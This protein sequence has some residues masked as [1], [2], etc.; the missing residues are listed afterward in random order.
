MATTATRFN[1]GQKTATA[2]QQTQT[3]QPAQAT[4]W[5]APSRDQI[6]ARAFEI[7]L[8]SGCKPGHDEKNWL[9]AEAELRQQG[10]KVNL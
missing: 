10:R 2:T 4:M 5:A 9:Q 3:K 7:Y 1:R 8:K 6:A